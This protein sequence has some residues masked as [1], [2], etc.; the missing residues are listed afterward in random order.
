MDRGEEK[1]MKTHLQVGRDIHGRIMTKC[2]LS[3]SAEWPLHVV[4]RQDLVTCRRCQEGYYDTVG[5]HLRKATR[6]KKVQPK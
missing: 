6:Y 3:H 1:E 4:D 2:K 5:H